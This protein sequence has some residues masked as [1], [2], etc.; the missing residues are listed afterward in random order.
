MK[1]P[2]NRI[3]KNPMR[4]GRLSRDGIPYQEALFEAEIESGASGY[5]QFP[6]GVFR[7]IAGHNLRYLVNFEEFRH[8]TIIGVI[9]RL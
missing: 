3:P 4:G 8:Y 1:H 2:R 6:L 5:E 9:L 7:T